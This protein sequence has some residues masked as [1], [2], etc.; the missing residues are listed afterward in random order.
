MFGQ[1][2][3]RANPC[4]ARRGHGIPQK[5]LPVKIHQLSAPDAIASVHSFAQGL[6]SHEATGRLREYGPNRMEPAPSVPVLLRLF[7]EFFHF[8]AAILWF[9]AA[10]ALLGEWIHEPCNYEQP[11]YGP[12]WHNLEVNL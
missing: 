5:R 10:L 2:T 8:F 7:K 9:A 11:W 1:V 6:S 4:T 3:V 12:Y